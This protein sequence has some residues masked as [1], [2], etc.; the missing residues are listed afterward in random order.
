[1]KPLFSTIVAGVMLMIAT[2]AAA[3]FT[4]DAVKTQPKKQIQN[5]MSFRDTMKQTSADAEFFSLARHKAERAAIRKE[6]N[7]LE[8]TGSLMA[9]VTA[10]NDPWVDVSGGDNS[11]ATVANVFV[12]H[13]FTKDLFTLES[14]FEGKFGYNRIKVEMNKTDA[15]G[16]EYIDREGIWFKNQDEFYFSVD[17][18]FKMAKNWSYG[19]SFKFRSQLARGYLSRT[20]QRRKDM[21]SSFMTPGYLDLSIGLKFKSPN[22]KLPFVVDL[23]PIALSAVYATN[24]WVRREQFDKDGKRIKKAFAYGI[25]DPDKNARYEGGS[26]IQ[27]DFDR[28]FGEDQNIRYRTTLFSFYGWI[29]NLALD[30]KYNSYSEY[31]DAYDRWLAK[32]DED[33]KTK[34]R[35][36]IHPTVRWENTVDIRATRYLTTSLSFQLY[37]NRSQTVRVQTKTLLSVGL[38]YTFK[39]K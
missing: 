1:M 16:A 26:S 5:Q 21:K 25:E 18:S 3:Q 32:G 13:T 29:T 34:P 9:S 31:C 36:A 6:R 38:S 35:L 39:N 15:N 8:V 24:D 4:I 33:I 7:T 22:Q 28:K 30:N 37:Y 20:E 19:G 2:P 17:P 14:K 23:S 11:I 27:I 10:Y 12:K